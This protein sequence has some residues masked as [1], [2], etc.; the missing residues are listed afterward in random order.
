MKRKIKTELKEQKPKAPSLALSVKRVSRKKEVLL[1][2]SESTPESVPTCVR[3]A[4][5]A[6]RVNTA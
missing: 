4:E 6:S 5:G 1:I 2:T 3:S